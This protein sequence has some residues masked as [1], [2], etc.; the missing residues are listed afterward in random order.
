[1]TRRIIAAAVF[2]GTAI[3]A[4]PTYAG[5]VLQENFNGET[6]DELNW[7]GNSN[8]LPTSPPGTVDLIGVGGAFDFLPGNGGYLDLDGS[9][10]TGNN[11]AGE[12]TSVAS[13]AAG[14]Y[15]L[16]FDL[17]GNRRNAPDQTTRIS[18]GNFSTDISLGSS[19][20]FTPYSFTFTTTG[21]NLIFTELGP[22]N[23]QGNLLDD[24]VLTAVP[25]PST[26][27]MMILGFLGLGFM[28]Y[29]RKFSGVA[30]RI[31]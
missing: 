19:A 7:T 16:T 6:P 24:V 20:G 2:L 23:Q 28:G 18:L 4:A 14:T 10:G 27:A 17:A 22:S 1:M 29:R 21:G 30:L 31:S 5:V 9:S 8:F 13:F 25:E 11:P 26:W 15:T 12:I 3:F